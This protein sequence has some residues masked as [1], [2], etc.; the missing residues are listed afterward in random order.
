[1]IFSFH[2]GTVTRSEH[3]PSHGD[4]R[5]LDGSRWPSSAVSSRDTALPNVSDSGGNQPGERILQRG[6]DGETSTLSTPLCK[7][8]FLKAIVTPRPRE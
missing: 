2:V 5:L 4:F 6:V 8:M 1:M 3:H 7:V